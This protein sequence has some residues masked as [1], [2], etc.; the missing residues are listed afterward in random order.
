[1]DSQLVFLLGMDRFLVRPSSLHVN[2][3]IDSVVHSAKDSTSESDRK[4]SKQGSRKRKYDASYIQ[5]GFIETS[6]GK[7]QCHM[8]AQF[9]HRSQQ[10]HSKE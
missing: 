7:P 4:P 9:S 2:Q 3:P 6:D 1:V 8:F 5:Y 10:A